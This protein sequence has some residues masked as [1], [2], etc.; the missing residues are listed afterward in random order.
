VAIITAA[1]FPGADRELPF[2]RGARL[3]LATSA[4]GRRQ[5]AAINAPIGSAIAAG[6]F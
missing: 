5:L 4:P 1:L 2:A 3:L 6:P